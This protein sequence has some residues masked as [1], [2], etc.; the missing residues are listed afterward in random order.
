MNLSQ[1]TRMPLHGGSA[2]MPDDSDY[3]EERQGI[4]G[5]SLIVLLRSIAEAFRSQDGLYDV[6]IRIGSHVCQ[7]DVCR[8]VRDGVA[9]G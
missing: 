1:S 6:S 8:Y 3:T 2:G 7:A 5:P 4:P 9:S